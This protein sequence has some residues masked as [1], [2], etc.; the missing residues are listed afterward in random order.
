MSTLKEDFLIDKDQNVAKSL[1][2]SYMEW[3][4]PQAP[5]PGRV[6]AH[7]QTE[8]VATWDTESQTSSPVIMHIDLDRTHSKARH[9]ALLEADLFQ[10]DRQALGRISTSPTLRRMRSTRH[11]QTDIRDPVRL[12][13][14]QEEDAQRESPGSPAHRHIVS[15][16]AV[17]P[18]CDEVL[19]LQNGSGPDSSTGRQ[20][21]RSHRSQTFDNGVSSPTQHYP[22][23][24]E[25][26]SC[27]GLVSL[28]D[29]LNGII[30]LAGYIGLGLP[31]SF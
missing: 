27:E 25:F 20:R 5:P 8:T 6:A 18:L 30:H 16:L 15:P 12:E 21:T 23:E 28:I 31:L 1:D 22:R 2:W 13:S 3:L 24:F 9:A 4:D 26:P 19:H 11:L 10:F 14:T 7:T 29:Y 17:G